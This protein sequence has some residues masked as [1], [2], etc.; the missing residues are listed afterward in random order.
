MDGFR[1]LRATWGLVREHAGA[2]VAL[3]VVYYG[4]V[5]VGAVFAAFNPELQELLIEAVGKVHGA[6]IT[7]LAEILDITKGGVSQM[8]NK[9]VEK[10]LIRK[11]KEL[12]NKRDV[13]LILTTLGKDIF[14][15]HEFFHQHIFE[16]FA[17]E[18]AQVDNDVLEKVDAFMEK[19][20]KG[21][22]CFINEF[23]EED[24]KCFCE[25]KMKEKGC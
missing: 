7:Q 1:T 10:K 3:N 14:E 24:F 5:V 17:A 9:L 6:N 21:M 2:Y 8:V 16:C 18:V 19:T 23:C 20:E 22:Q 15:K 4:L 11:V 25:M 12:G 13:L